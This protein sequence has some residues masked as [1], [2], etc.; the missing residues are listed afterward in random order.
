MKVFNRA[1]KLAGYERVINDITVQVL[2]YDGDGKVLRASGTTVPTGAGYAK[3][4]LFAKTDAASGTK[5][6]YENQGTTATASFNLVGAVGDAEIAFSDGGAI[7][8][9]S[10]NELVEF[11]VTASAV[12]HLKITNA[13]TG[14]DP[15][16]SA[17]GGDTDIDMGL[18]PKGAG[19]VQIPAA[20]GIK[21]SV[22]NLLVPFMPSVVQQA[23]SGAGAVNLTTFYTAVTNTGSDAL[24]LADSTVNGQLK[25]VK[26]I[27][28][29]GTDSTLTFNANATIGL[30]VVGYYAVLMWNGSDWLPVELGNDADGTSAPAYTPAS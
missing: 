13:A 3:G 30:A 17:V 18:T 28:D 14:N 21:S 8:D 20:S 5:G 22:S 1:V 19:S 4:C 26:M 12:N 24:T 29:P 11:G 9:S 6:L 10:A 25:K 15:V 16:L 2:E 27:V 7:D 23:L